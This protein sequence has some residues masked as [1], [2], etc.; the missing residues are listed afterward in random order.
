M[1]LLLVW[2]VRSGG[3]SQNG[4]LVVL[5]EVLS[6]PA[7]ISSTVLLAAVFPLMVRVLWSLGVVHS[8][9]GSSQDRPLSFL[10]EVLPRAGSHCFGCLCSLPVEMSNRRCRLDCLCYSLLGRFRSSRC[11][12]SRA[13]GCCVGQLVSLF[14]SKFSR[15]CW[16]TLC[17]P[18]VRVRALPDG[19]L[20]SV[21]GARLAVLPVEASVPHCGL[22]LARGKDSLCVF[23]LC[24]SLP[25]RLLFGG[26]F[27]FL[28]PGVLSQMVVW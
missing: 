4:A 27:R 21:V 15:P 26:L 6:G 17:V 8:G 3:F 23:F 25:I 19:G 14:V 22:P 28:A 20:V 12:L 10:V 11:A 9:E 24:F 5:V 16:W 13:S 1:L 7:C 18:R 2:L